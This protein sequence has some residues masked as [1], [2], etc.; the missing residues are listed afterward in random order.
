MVF[1]ALNTFIV[2]A[3]TSYTLIVYHLYQPF[4]VRFTYWISLLRCLQA[5]YQITTL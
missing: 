2:N 4:E 1:A 3:Q 5:V